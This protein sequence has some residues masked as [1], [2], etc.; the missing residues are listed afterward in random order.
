VGNAVDTSRSLFD[1]VEAG[2]VTAVVGNHGV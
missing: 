1:V 2:Q